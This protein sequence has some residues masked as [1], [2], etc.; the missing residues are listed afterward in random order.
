METQNNAKNVII[1]AGITGLAAAYVLNKNGQGDMHIFESE[2]FI[3]G[4]GRT[5]VYKEFRFDLGGHRFYTS[6]EEV[7]RLVQEVVGPDMLTVDRISRI[8]LNGR[9]ADYPLTFMSSLSVLSLWTAFVAGL[10]YLANRIRRIFVKK[11]IVSFE[12]WIVNRFGWK[13]YSIFFKPYSEKVW[14]VPCTELAADFAG[15]RIKGLSLR[16][17]VQNI[18]QKK[19]TKHAS[20]VR[21]FLYPR[22]GFGQIGENMARTLKPGTVHLSSPVIGCRHNGSVITEVLV[23]EP[24]GEKRSYPC[25]DVVMTIPI[26]DFV[27]MLD[28]LPPQEV[29][30]AASQLRYRDI[31]ICYVALNRKQVTPDHWI[32]FSTPDTFFGRFHEPKNW[33][34]SMAPA[35]AT[36]LVVEVFCFK[37]DPVWT[38]PDEQL[39]ARIVKRLDELGMIK[40]GEYRGGTVVRLE[41]AYP[42]YTI[43]YQQQVDVLMNYLK[44]FKNL[45]CAGRNGVFR[46]SSGDRHIEMG[47][48]TGQNILGAQHDVHKVGAEQEYAEK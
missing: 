47:I 10:S 23:K 30:A 28:P 16:E 24:S 38:E 31:I 8:Y 14:G 41:K 42:L 20:L 15:Q 12:D 34:P 4:A 25:K 46:Y 2:P 37:D 33:S 44:R 3:N 7:K 1:G 5:E 43:G 11:P 9:F 26:T 40:A 6:N 27:R 35:D 19:S 21:Q 17:V 18:F 29:L 48:K 36:G 39:L 45:H 13:L 32:Y 22:Y